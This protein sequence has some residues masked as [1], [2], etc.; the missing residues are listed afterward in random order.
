MPAA[1]WEENDY[2]LQLFLEAAD[3]NGLRVEPLN[4]RFGSRAVDADGVVH[5]TLDLSIL[6]VALK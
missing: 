6:E 3:E 1:T 5:M 2:A 4:T